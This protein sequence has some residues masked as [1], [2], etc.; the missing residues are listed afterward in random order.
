MHQSL[1]SDD[2]VQ[3]PDLLLT[4]CVALGK[5]LISL[6]PNFKICKMVIIIYLLVVANGCGKISQKIL[7]KIVWHSSYLINVVFFLAKDLFLLTLSSFQTR[8]K[9]KL[10]RYLTFIE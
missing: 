4:S 1:E 8:E 2:Y 3:I 6:K 5:S 10:S 9:S 7:M